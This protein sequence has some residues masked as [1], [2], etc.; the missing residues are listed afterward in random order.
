MAKK[1]TKVAGPAGAGKAENTRRSDITLGV[2]DPTLPHV[3]PRLE[4]PVPPRPKHTTIDDEGRLV[5]APGDVHFVVS[6]RR[7]KLKCYYV[8]TLDHSSFR[9]QVEA[10]CYGANGPG[11]KVPGGDTP[12][13]PYRI[14]QIHH[15]GP[16]D[17]QAAAFGPVFLDLEELLDQ[18]RKFGRAGVGAH[19][20][21]SGLE[22]PWHAAQQGW[23]VTYGCVRLQNADLLRVLETVQWVRKQGG[24]AWMTVS[25]D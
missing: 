6:G 20:G 5:I 19:G 4:S 21:G 7:K 16:D 24:Q 14:G 1:T 18:E 10:R 3:D 2:V 13:G 23:Q 8:D 15:I 12:P 11:W 9:Y 22:D 17:P 25:W